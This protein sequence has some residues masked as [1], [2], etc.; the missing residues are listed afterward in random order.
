MGL[1][2]SGIGFLHY[3][4]PPCFV[5]DQRCSFVAIPEH[6]VNIGP[7]LIK[8]RIWGRIRQIIPGNEWKWRESIVRYDDKFYLLNKVLIKVIFLI[9]LRDISRPSLPP[10]KMALFCIRGHETGRFMLEKKGCKLDMFFLK[11]L[12]AGIIFMF[13]TMN[14]NKH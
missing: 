4:G 7:N 10:N 13:L 3:K 9:L 6:N 1:L 2:F 11:T 14:V 8:G 5:W 12:K